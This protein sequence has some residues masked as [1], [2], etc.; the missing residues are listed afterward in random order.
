LIYRKSVYFR[1]LGESRPYLDR[2]LAAIGCM[3]LSSIC[4][5][6]PPWLLKNVVDD[7]LIARKMM[8]LNLICVGLVILFICKAFATYGHQYLMNWVGQRVV[9]DLRSKLYERMQSLSLKYIN[10]SRVGE[11]MSRIT[12]DVNVLQNM[13][14]T[15]IVDLV[16][17]GITFLGMLGFMIYINWRL[18]LVTFAIIPFVA[19]I[20]SVASKKLRMVGHDIQEKVAMLSAVVQEAISAIRIV[21]S[22]ATEEMEMERFRARNM[23][24]F[25]AI[26]KRTQIQAVL[27][28]LIEVFLISF[29]ALILWI[30]GRQVILGNSTPGELIA[31]LGY[32]GFLAQPLRVYTRVIS[33]MQH[34]MASCDRI[35]D[36]LDT[37]AEIRTPSDPVFLD[38]M[39]GK[40]EFRDLWF[41]YEEDQWVF[42]GLDLLVRSGENIAIVGPTGVGK[43]TLVDFI[44]RFYDPRSGQVL[45][46]DHDVKTLDLKSLRKQIGVVPQDPVL[47]KG[48]IAFNISYGFPGAT[49]EDIREA[50]RIAG[51]SDFI[52]ALPKGY[53]TEIGERGV[54]LSGGQRQRVAIARAII[55]DP[56]ILIMDEA[57]SS[58]D[59]EVEKQIQ[60]AMEK[61]MQGRTSFIIAH[62]LSTI[63]NAHRII[64]LS[65]GKVV[66]TGTHEDLM[67]LGGHYFRLYQLQFGD[68][69]EKDS[70]QLP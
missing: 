27:T 46:D 14:T 42:R 48:T 1:L 44:P 23:E 17:Q 66:E 45:I 20:L 10:S 18:T 22:F 16:V 31:F 37:Q 35:F 13:M 55:R 63:R 69:N 9:M 3:F 25:R 19:W 40:V 54:T 6:I 36:L 28:G 15:V 59:V 50:A 49:P 21:L 68:Q 11:L 57:T 41:A 33:G 60:E 61:A 34:G 58:L 67:A 52:E 30:G 26:M 12:N 2:L 65:G 29:L 38:K 43:S 32:L 24:N 8:V 64:V 53:D 51:I 47:M 56:R 7:V 62:R 5:I 70:Q 39:K 4:T